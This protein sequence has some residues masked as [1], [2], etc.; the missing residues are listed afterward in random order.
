MATKKRS[1]TSRTSSAKRSGAKNAQQRKRER[2]RKERLRKQRNQ[3]I[4][5]VLFAFAILL[6]CVVLI[7]GGSLW[8]VFHNVM[9][10]LFGPW[11]ILWPIFLLYVSITLAVEKPKPTAA[12]GTV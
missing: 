6:G 4:A 7:Q 12:T 1:T 5:V 9:L 11:A 10:G 8:T 2:E 3:K